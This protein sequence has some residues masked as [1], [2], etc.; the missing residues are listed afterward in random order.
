M[1]KMTGPPSSTFRRKRNQGDADA[2][3]KTDGLTFDEIRESRVSKRPI[4]WNP[5]AHRPP[6]PPLRSSLE[7]WRVACILCV[8]GILPK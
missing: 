5:F 7:L 1:A 2:K 3:R 8:S 4:E 6:P